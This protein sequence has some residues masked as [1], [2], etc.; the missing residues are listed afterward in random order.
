[1]LDRFLAASS[2]ST[3]EKEDVTIFLIIYLNVL[4]TH[5]HDKWF[6]F[7]NLKKILVAQKTHTLF[8]I[9]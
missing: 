6:G 4:N 3:V 5:A 1:M 2:F 7:H 8:S 9:Q